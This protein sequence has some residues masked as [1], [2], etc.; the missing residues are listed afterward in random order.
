[1]KEIENTELSS[2]IQTSKI[3]KGLSWIISTLKEL[4]KSEYTYSEI[5]EIFKPLFT[6]H[7]LVWNKNTSI[8]NYFPEFVK[9]QKTVNK[10]REI[11]YR[12]K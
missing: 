7:N 6:L 9:K 1:M 5:E 10:K 8:K 4:D 12:F 2:E 11:Y 3:E